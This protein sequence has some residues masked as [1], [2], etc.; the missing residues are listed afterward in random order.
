MLDPRVFEREI[1]RERRKNVARRALACKPVRHD[2]FP[3]GGAKTVCQKR[4][5]ATKLRRHLRPSNLD[6]WIEFCLREK[7]IGVLECAEDGARSEIGFLI[8]QS[9]DN[10]EVVVFV[11]VGSRSEEPNESFDTCSQIVEEASR[12]IFRLDRFVGPLPGWDGIK[13]VIKKGDFGTNPRVAPDELAQSLWRFLPVRTGV[14]RFGMQIPAIAGIG[15]IG[16]DVDAGSALTTVQ[17]A[18]SEVPGGIRLGSVNDFRFLIG[19][20]NGLYKRFQQPAIFFGIWNGI[21][22][23]DV[24]LIPQSPVGN[25]PAKMLYHPSRVAAESGDLLRRFWR[26]KD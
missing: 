15:V 9:V 20:M 5:I 2:G 16:I 17:R 11:A 26:P 23:I 7:S 21:P 19:L 6:R 13:L 1:R 24:L 3:G 14:H 18:L 8:R 22:V 25:A 10:A 12:N 4:I